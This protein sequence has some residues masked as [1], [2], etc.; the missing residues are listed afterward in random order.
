MT[1]FA[2]QTGNTLPASKTFDRAISDLNLPSGFQDGLRE[3]TSGISTD[4]NGFTIEFPILDNPANAI[5][6]LLMGK[7]RR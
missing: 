2:F 6:Q 4:D 7:I 3:I 5:F 1:S